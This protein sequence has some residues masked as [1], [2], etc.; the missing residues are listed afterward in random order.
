MDI[1]GFENDLDWSKV[2]PVFAFYYLRKDTYDISSSTIYQLT[3]RS[4]FGNISRYVQ[5]ASLH[6]PLSD[7]KKFEADYIQTQLGFH[8]Q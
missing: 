5:Q 8:W 1:K 3:N 6:C 2:S 7:R 4:F